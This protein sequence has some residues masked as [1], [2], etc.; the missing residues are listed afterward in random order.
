MY[1]Y[2]KNI[3]FPLLLIVMP[4]RRIGPECTSTVRWAVC[5]TS[6]RLCLREMAGYPLVEKQRW[7][8]SLPAGGD[9]NRTSVQPTAQSLH[10]LR[11][12][13]SVLNVILIWTFIFIRCCG[14]L[15]LLLTEF[16]FCSP[17]VPVQF[18]FRVPTVKADGWKVTACSL[19]VEVCSTHNLN[20]LPSCVVPRGNMKG[21]G[22]LAVWVAGKRS[23]C[24]NML[25]DACRL[26]WILEYSALVS[27]CSHLKQLSNLPASQ[28]AFNDMFH[29]WCG[30]ARSGNL[31]ARTPH[32]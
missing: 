22:M 20:P 26:Q 17:A 21:R 8:Q 18:R 10:W 32:L 12:P 16:R 1:V 14:W 30:T 4:W 23:R 2:R 13:I 27:R 6:L 29:T 25:S 11:C 15:I 28:Q 31:I 19:H 9:G 7:S 24:C 3:K 5:L